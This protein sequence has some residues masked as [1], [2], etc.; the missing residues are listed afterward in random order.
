MKLEEI[1]RQLGYPQ[2]GVQTVKSATRCW[3]AGMACDYPLAL[4]LTLKQTVTEVTPVGTRRRALTEADC[5]RVA[6]RF[7][8]KLNRVVFG[9]HAAERH[10]KT[11]R[12]IPVLEGRASGKRLHLHFAIGGLP[13]H[14]RFNRF[15]GLVREAKQQVSQLDT[16][17]RVDI[18]DSGWMEYISKETGSEHSDN[19]LWDRAQ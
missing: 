16:Q 1:R 13:Q 7:Q 15:D 19:V 10:G 4:T 6:Q 9:K 5:Q 18:T 11:L 3:L 14:I 17:H 8:Q 12:Y 2:T